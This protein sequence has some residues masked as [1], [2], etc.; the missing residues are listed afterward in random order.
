MLS[1][2]EYINLFSEKLLRVDAELAIIDE[3]IASLKRQLAQRDVDTDR[4]SKTP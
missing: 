2:E 1:K 4:R 3:E